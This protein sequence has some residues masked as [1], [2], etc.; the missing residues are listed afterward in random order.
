MMS[1]PKLIKDFKPNPEKYIHHLPIIGSEVKK[2]INSFNSPRIGI[3]WKGNPLHPKNHQR[4]VTPDFFN[5][6]TKQTG[7]KFFVLQKE[8]LDNYFKGESFIDLSPYFADFSHTGSLIKSLDLVITVDTS[9]AH[10]SGAMGKETWL[11]LSF[12]ADWRW[13]IDQQISNWYSSIKI[14]RQSNPDN[15]INVQETIKIKLL[16]LINR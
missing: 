16:N 10:L 7:L 6:L 2:L 11:I 4:S 13:G 5:E 8:G 12:N 15:W 3:V 1:I 9:T 14:F